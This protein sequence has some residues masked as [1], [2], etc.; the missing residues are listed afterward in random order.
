M[1]KMMIT[2]VL[3]MTIAVSAS[4]MSYREA[5]AAARMMTDRMAVELRL[6]HRQYDRVYEINLRYMDHPEMKDRAMS[7]VLTPHQF[8]RYM[9]HRHTLHAP[10]LAHHRVHAPAPKHHRGQGPAA[11]KHVKLHHRR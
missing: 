9:H 5:R 3:M 10:A 6:S 2:L 1:K 7:R 11:P 4:A 8:D